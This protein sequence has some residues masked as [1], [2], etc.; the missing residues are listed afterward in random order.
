MKKI[1]LLFCGILI[2]FSTG[3]RTGEYKFDHVI[4]AATPALLQAD[5]KLKGKLFIN[6]DG[7]VKV[8]FEKGV[9]SVWFAYKLDESTRMVACGDAFRIFHDQYINNP[10]VKKKDGKWRREKIGCKGYVEDTELYVLEWDLNAPKP[11]VTSNR[12]GNFI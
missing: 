6:E 5:E 9:M 4:Y 12:Y 8:S 7:S 10:D 2:L 3:C 11:T 1:C